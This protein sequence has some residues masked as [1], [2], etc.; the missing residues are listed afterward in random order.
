MIL[1]LSY[2]I[3]GGE[4]AAKA[5]TDFQLLLLAGTETTTNLIAICRADHRQHEARQAL[6]VHGPARLPIQ[7]EPGPRAAAQA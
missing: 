5:S 2:T 1:A 7:F 4:G 6:H 3:S